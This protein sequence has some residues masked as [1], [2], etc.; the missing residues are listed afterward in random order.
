MC[1][2]RN[3]GYTRK[4]TIGNVTHPVRLQF[5]PDNA[6]WFTACP[7]T[8]DDLRLGDDVVHGHVM[9]FNQLVWDV[10]NLVTQLTHMSCNTGQ[11]KHIL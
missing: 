10:H 9:V 3:Y 2:V 11:T 6:D 1:S 4:E 5:G 8:L 7:V